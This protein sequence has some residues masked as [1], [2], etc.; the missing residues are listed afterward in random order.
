LL[1][2]TR[3]THCRQRC[4]F[5]SP[6]IVV[7]SDVHCICSKNAKSTGNNQPPAATSTTRHHVPVNGT[8]GYFEP[9]TGDGYDYTYIEPSSPTTADDGYVVPDD[10]SPR[11]IPYYM[12]PLPSPPASSNADVGQKPNTECANQTSSPGVNSGYLAPSEDD[13]VGGE[14]YL[15][16]SVENKSPSEEYTA[17]QLPDNNVGSSST[18]SDR[19]NSQP[20][21]DG[22]DLTPIV[23]HQYEQ[24]EINFQLPSS[25]RD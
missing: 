9:I 18:D 19:V 16:L 3:I 11:P 22:G 1:V 14:H 7:R 10:D 4:Y 8:D 25:V 15:S 5:N 13:A 12:A 20:T 24:S 23:R 6:V 21:D 17:L 2:Y